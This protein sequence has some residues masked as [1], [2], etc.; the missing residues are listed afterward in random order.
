MGTAQADLTRQEIRKIFSLR[1]NRGSQA[2]VAR[3]ADVSYQH[4]NSWLKGTT[5]SANV[6][7]VAQAYAQ[8]LMAKDRKADAA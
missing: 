8:E 3:R 1:R 4:V 7:E 6:A 5:T 2:E